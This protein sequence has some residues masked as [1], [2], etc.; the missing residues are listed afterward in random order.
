MYTFAFYVQPWSRGGAGASALWDLS[1]ELVWISLWTDLDENPQQNSGAH[2][3]LTLGLLTLSQI[4]Q[5][6]CHITSFHGQKK[7]KLKDCV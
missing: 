2:K 1:P 3:A 6:L 4:L 7:N 5:N